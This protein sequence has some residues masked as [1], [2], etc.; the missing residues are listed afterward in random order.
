MRA[1]DDGTRITQA[2]SESMERAESGAGARGWTPDAV[3]LRAILD[4]AQDAIV[5]IDAD[6]RIVEANLAVERL[7]GR[8]RD[9]LVGGDLGVILPTAMAATHRGYVASVASGQASPHVGR[10]R[11]LMA[12]HADGTTFPVSIALNALETDGR[13]IYVGV[14][15]DV[16]AEVAQREELIQRRDELHVQALINRVILH[17]RTIDALLDGVLKALVGALKVRGRAG[18]FLADEGQRV[19][20]LAHTVGEFDADFLAREAEV[21]YGSCLC[22]RAAVCRE[23]VTSPSCFKD[24]R[25]D[26]PGDRS[27]EHGHFIVPLVAEDDLIGVIFLYTD[28]TPAWD[29]R[30]RELF[31][32]LGITTAGA[33]RRLQVEAELRASREQLLYLATH[34]PLTES[35]NRRLALER[36]EAELARGRRTGNSV[37]IAIFDIDHFKAINDTHGHLV[38][39]AVLREVATRLSAAVRGYDV[40]GRFGGE[41]FIVVLPEASAEVA[42]EAAERLRLCIAR[43]P[44]RCDGLEVQ[45]RASCGVA[46]CAGG[47]SSEDLLRAADAALYRAK[48]AGRDRVEIAPP[49]A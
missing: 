4:A 9:A 7:F 19:L 35:P 12:T 22:G 31:E 47:G 36:L 10:T 40:C 44:V 45:V 32:T 2:A 30:R 8:S 16:R 25:H 41:E 49:R 34:D 11:E 3:S 43:D 42:G 14:M 46:A 27:N 5:A 20:R 23:V 24:L 18:A 6:H 39:D 1:K 15:R 28:V 33:I 21:P 13:S 29:D 17:A 38:G 37:A 26:R 48:D